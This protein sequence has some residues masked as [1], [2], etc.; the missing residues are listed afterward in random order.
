MEMEFNFQNSVSPYVDGPDSN[1]RC[2]PTYFDTRRGQKWH[3]KALKVTGK[4]ILKYSDIQSA[5]KHPGS[6]GFSEV[7]ETTATHEIVAAL[8]FGKG[9]LA[10]SL[11]PCFGDLTFLLCQNAGSSTG[12]PA[13]YG[14]RQG[15]AE[16]TGFLL[17]RCCIYKKYSRIHISS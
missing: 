4:Q 5:W 8:T 12:V 7:V 10:S 9:R 13:C 11:G 14:H 15:E 17:V 2:F 16:R 1:G 6:I 3:L